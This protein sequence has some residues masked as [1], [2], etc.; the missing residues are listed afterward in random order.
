MGYWRYI[1]ASGL[2]SRLRVGSSAI[3]ECEQLGGNASTSG[4]R[5]DN[6]AVLFGNIRVLKSVPSASRIL[7]V[8]AV[9][10]VRPSEGHI[11]LNTVT[12]SRE[13][14]YASNVLA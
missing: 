1:R 13:R 9:A 10:R 8:G 3:T 2:S 12:L 7:Q 11:W 5:T 4:Q 14:N 6:H